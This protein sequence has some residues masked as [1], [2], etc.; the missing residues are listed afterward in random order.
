MIV[1][2]VSRLNVKIYV[3]MYIQDLPSLNVQ[4]LPSVKFFCKFA[5]FL[6]LFWNF[7][8]IKVCLK[9]FKVHSVSYNNSI[10]HNF[11]K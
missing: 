7:F 11:L 5:I 6:A 4:I 10:L 1:T 2:K 3:Y 8:N 9:D